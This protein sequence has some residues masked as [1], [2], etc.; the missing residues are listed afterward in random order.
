M[1]RAYRP[2]F[3][4]PITMT[5]PPPSNLLNLRVAAQLKRN[6]KVLQIVSFYVLFVFCSI[7]FS[8]S[9][10]YHDDKQACT[11]KP[12]IPQN[13]IKKLSSIRENP[14][15][16][17][18]PRQRLFFSRWIFNNMRQASTKRVFHLTFVV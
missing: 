2:L 1:L 10:H 7:N 6:C 8:P 5:S 14:I 9:K 3:K 17:V 12:N 16:E 15:C 13:L 18:E 11:T 4:G